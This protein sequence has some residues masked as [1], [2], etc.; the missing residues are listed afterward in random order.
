VTALIAQRSAPYRQ[1]VRESNDNPY[2]LPLSAAVRTWDFTHVSLVKHFWG[3]PYAVAAVSKL[4]GLDLDIC[5]VLISVSSLFMA[6][7]LIAALWGGGIALFWLASNYAIVMT[8]AFGGAEPLFFALVFGAF[9]CVR[10]DRWLLAM[11]LAAAASTVRPIGVFAV[12]AIQAAL[13]LNRKWRVFSLG[14]AI[15]LAVAFAYLSGLRLAHFDL[16]ANYAGYQHEDWTGGLV[17]SL[18]FLAIARNLM[19]GGHMGHPAV[20]AVKILFVVG[21]V[22]LLGVCVRR[23]RKDPS[24]L[25]RADVLFALAYSCFCLAYNAPE[26]SLSIYPRLVSPALPIL[27]FVA[28]G[29]DLK[30]PRPALAGMGVVSILL[31]AGSAIGAAQRSGGFHFSP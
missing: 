21:H 2:Y 4:T 29:G 16:L 26:W 30:L 28:A 9:A 22:V 31:A 27:L 15:A 19:N 1:I 3:L 24:P 18:P 6:L 12:V 23:L 5:L 14:S 25:R 20:A 8:A 10:R 7:W 13:L 11:F 17:V